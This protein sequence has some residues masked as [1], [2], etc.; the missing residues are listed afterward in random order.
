MG[1]PA[2]VAHG[3]RGVPIRVTRSVPTTPSRT[4]LSQSFEAAVHPGGL[5]VPWGGPQDRSRAESASL[6]TGNAAASSSPDVEE[7]TAEGSDG[8]Q[9][10]ESHATLDDISEVSVDCTAGRGVDSVSRS[11]AELTML[12]CELSNCIQCAGSLTARL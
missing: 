3:L 7:T 2:G 5:A 12:F 9:L 6:S 4:D 8:G 11:P 1:S 10:S